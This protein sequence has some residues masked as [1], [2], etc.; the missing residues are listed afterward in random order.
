M[1]EAVATLSVVAKSGTTPDLLVTLRAAWPLL[2]ASERLPG[3]S[4]PWQQSFAVASAKPCEAEI[5]SY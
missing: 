3:R 4:I 5:D 1:L 2:P